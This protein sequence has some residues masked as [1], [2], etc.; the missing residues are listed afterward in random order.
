[1]L[2]S[3]PVAIIIFL[4][5]LQSAGKAQEQ[6]E[7]RASLQGCVND[8]IT[9]GN[10]DKAYMGRRGTLVL[11]CSDEPARKLYTVLTHILERNVIFRNR[12]KGTQRSFGQSMCSAVRQKADG[13]PKEEFVC[14]IAISVGDVVLELL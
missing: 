10:F 4:F 3:I 8:A 6:S 5:A 12:D 11:L 2:R 9:G 13:S 7:L 1:M 14:R